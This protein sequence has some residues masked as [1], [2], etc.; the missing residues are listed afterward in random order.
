VTSS[1]HKV[2]KCPRKTSPLLDVLML[3]RKQKARGP[4]AEQAGPRQIAGLASLQ[5]E[6]EFESALI[7]W[8]EAHGWT[9]H[10]ERPAMNKQGEWRTPIRGRRGYPD[11][12]IARKG[13][14]WWLEEKSEKGKADA[15]QLWWLQELGPH[16]RIV[17]PSDWPWIEEM[18]A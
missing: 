10:A 11:L 9:V 13:A 1:M 15:D 6:A 8:L 3:E 16:A 7:P 17:R 2:P 5:S 4:S 12:T 14:A 18:L